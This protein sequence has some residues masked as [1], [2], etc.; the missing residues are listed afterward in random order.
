MRFNDMSVRAVLPVWMNV[1]FRL[2]FN[3][4]GCCAYNAT[5]SIVL[6]GLKWVWFFRPDFDPNLN[7]LYDQKLVWILSEWW[8]N[9][10]SKIQSGKLSAGIGL[11][12]AT[13]SNAILSNSDNVKCNTSN[14]NQKKTEIQSKDTLLL[15]LAAVRRCCSVPFS[16]VLFI[17]W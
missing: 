1:F 11:D 3:I 10:F 8:K 4:T 12:S 13:T 5:D 15:H 9:V 17:L 2:S 6:M 14:H 7:A 16:F